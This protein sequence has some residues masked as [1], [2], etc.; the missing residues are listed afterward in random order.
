LHLPVAHD[1]TSKQITICNDDYKF[2]AFL[3]NILQEFAVINEVMGIFH[4]EIVMTLP[5]QRT[6]S[7]MVLKR[8]AS[9]S[10]ELDIPWDLG[11]S[12]TFSREDS[13]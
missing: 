8:N 9:I 10:Y 7:C 2:A 11:I 3:H 5:K 1:E 13:T 6:C 4:P 12:V